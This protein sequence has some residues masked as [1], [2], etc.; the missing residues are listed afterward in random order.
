MVASN[1]EIDRVP[2]SVSPIESGSLEIETDRF[3][4]CRENVPSGKSFLMRETVSSGES[5]ELITRRVA[6]KAYREL[7]AG[8]CW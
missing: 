6:E 4:L 2:F 7:T 5:D 8:I 3:Y 1:Y